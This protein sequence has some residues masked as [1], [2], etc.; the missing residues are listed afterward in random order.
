MWL[1]NYYF[2]FSLFGTIM[3]VLGI[4]LFSSLGVWQASRA[5]EK[6]Q[7]QEM[8]DAR[9]ANAPVDLKS[10]L[11]DLEN[12]IFARV[13][14]SG[15]Y[16]SQ[17]EILI[18]N[19]VHKGQAGYH[20]VSPLQLDNGAVILVDRGW[21]PT[22]RDRNVL[23]SIDTPKSRVELKG[24]L[25]LPKSKPAL[26]LDNSEQQASK[27]W[28]Y[29][30]LEKYQEHSGL[31][32]LPFIMLLSDQSQDKTI[33]DWPKYDAKAGMHIGYSIQWFAFA[34]IVLVTYFGV[35]IKKKNRA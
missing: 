6:L 9:A 5:S 25:A 34:V 24:T 13:I 21:I 29:L 7:L 16:L 14:A 32:V 27:L 11:S 10:V 15:Y 1:K 30:D 31:A 22:G 28:P 18:D 3:A 33:R 17:H 19:Q 2:R 12:N 35:N 26:V 20:L 8:I 23:P 4:V